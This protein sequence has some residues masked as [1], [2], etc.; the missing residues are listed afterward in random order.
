M[1]HSVSNRVNKLQSNALLTQIHYT[2]KCKYKH[3]IYINNKKELEVS[4]LPPEMWFLI[5]EG[6]IENSFVGDA[7]W[8]RGEMD[9]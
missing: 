4:F 2:S 3:F 6:A 5:R 7:Y 9:V 8:G 1:S